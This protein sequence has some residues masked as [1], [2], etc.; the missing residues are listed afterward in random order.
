MS[1]KLPLALFFVFYS[2]LTLQAQFKF[3]GDVNKEF[4]NA[5]VY[6][7]EIDDYKKTSVFFN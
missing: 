3:S 1:N 2:F 6:L 5:T 4:I 7:T